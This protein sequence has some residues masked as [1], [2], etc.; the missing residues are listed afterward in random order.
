MTIS[1]YLKDNK[2][3]V[4]TLI[5]ARIN[6]GGCKFK[7]YTKEKI[8]PKDWNND[9]QEARKTLNGY[10]SFNHLLTEIK[11][12][13]FTVCN[14][15]RVKNDTPPIE[16]I[17]SALDAKLNPTRKP[18]NETQDFFT[19]FKNII[20]DSKSGARL[21]P[22]TGKPISPNTIKTYVT[23]YQHLSDFQ[24]TIRK[25]IDFNSIDLD[26]YSDYTKYLTT[27]KNLASNSLGKHIQII[28]LIMND[29]TERGLNTNLD[30]KSKRFITIRE[31]V[32]SIYLNEKE[33]LAMGSLDLS[34]EPRLEKVRDMFLIGCYTGLRFSDFSTL[35]P[36]DI[37]NDMIR[38]IQQKVKQP[39]IVPIHD[40]VKEIVL[41][42]NGVLPK[43]IS[44]QKMNDYIKEVG[45]KIECLQHKVSITYTKG[46]QSIT[47]I[48]EKYKEIVTHTA[49]RSF[50]SNEYLAGTPVISIMAISGHKTEKAFMKYIK[51][52]P[53][54]HAKILSL[55]WESRKETKRIPLGKLA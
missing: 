23:T 44:N 40:K 26:F 6:L 31:K 33:L 25:K 10:A 30:F 18:K 42:Y 29:A 28:K 39:V 51:L 48:N 22:I 12:T 49:R 9:K 45:E 37:E 27:T 21:N 34:N 17:K 8:N 20:D 38:I 50:C 15:F 3:N 53:N 41:K 32:D 43:A 13:I 1:F 54:E 5:Y 11:S 2:A 14:E 7:Y 36:N 16:E 47:R 52:T 46:G 4:P 24:K 55:S 19:F 35:N